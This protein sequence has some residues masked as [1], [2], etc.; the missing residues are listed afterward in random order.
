MTGA[1]VDAPRYRG[2]ID[3]AGGVI[4]SALGRPALPRVYQ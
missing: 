1:L 2:F 3:S 4:P